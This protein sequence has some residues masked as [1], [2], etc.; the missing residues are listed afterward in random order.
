MVAFVL[1][2]KLFL[3]RKLRQTAHTQLQSVNTVNKG[4][5]LFVPVGI[6]L[7][8]LSVINVWFINLPNCSMNNS[9]SVLERKREE[10]QAPLLQL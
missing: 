9:N 2:W 5:C 7:F 6:I 1:H 10:G 8:S 4:V 3:G